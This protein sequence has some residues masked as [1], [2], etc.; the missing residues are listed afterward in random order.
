MTAPKKDSRG[1]LVTARDDGPQNLVQLVDRM[2][3]Q[4]AAALPKTMRPERMARLA[5]TALRTT[6]RLGECTPRSF[7]GS[8][9]Q[10]AQLG[11]EPNTPLG[12]AY[13]IPRANRRQGTTEA[14][15][16]L[17]Y[18][19]ILTLARRSGEVDAV[20]ACSVFEGDEYDVVRG[21][22]P[23]LVHVPRGHEDPARITHVYAVAHL[24]GSNIPVFESLTREQLE[25]RR[26]RSPASGSGPWVT[27]YQ[28]MAEKTAIR[29][30]ARWL[31][32][33]PELA[34]GAAMDEA[35]EVGK[36]QEQ[37][38]TEETHDALARANLDALPGGTDDEPDDEP[39]N[40]QQEAT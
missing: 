28:R 25:A 7:I 10:C 1:Q 32:Q 21:A 12:E 19:G 23:N 5:M 9:M 22:H 36:R 29:A 13:L 37:Y 30:L 33:S 18:K 31:P 15:F 8:L 3:G 6:P 38:W 35:P 16:L 17:G 26:N 34:R 40:V 14:T 2:R 4:L 27:D 24:R 39:A 11:L 20:W